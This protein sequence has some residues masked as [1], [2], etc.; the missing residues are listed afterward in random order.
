MKSSI[1][2]PIQKTYGLDLV[3]ENA[4][5]ASNLAFFAK[6]LEQTVVNQLFIIEALLAT[7]QLS[8]YRQFHYNESAV[9][10]VYKD[11]L[12][13]MVQQ[14]LTLLVLLDLNA[15]FD[16]IDHKHIGVRI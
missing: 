3:F 1:L 7:N 12:L 5:P 9:L 4:R 6:D 14:K 10:K 16:P 15:A 11:I 8:C 2:A 13:P